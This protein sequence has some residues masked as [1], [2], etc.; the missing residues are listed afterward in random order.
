MV[1][2][3]VGRIA[4]GPSWLWTMDGLTIYKVTNGGIIRSGIFYGFFARRK[5]RTRVVRVQ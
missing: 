4:S 5:D 3:V 1:G 2:G